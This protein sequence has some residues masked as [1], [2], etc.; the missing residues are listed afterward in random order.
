MVVLLFLF[1]DALFATL[2]R[3]VLVPPP[4][5]HFLWRALS[6]LLVHCSP[7]GTVLI[8][9]LFLLYYTVAALD[10]FSSSLDVIVWRADLVR[11]PW[12]FFMER[13]VCCGSPWR[14]AFGVRVLRETLLRAPL[15][16]HLVAWRTLPFAAE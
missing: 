11:L 8:P 10:L 9:S 4:V 2:W 5:H 1:S 7:Q 12:F 13:F 15:V 16:S 3:T 6:C 14:G